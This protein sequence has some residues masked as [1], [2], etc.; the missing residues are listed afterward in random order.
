LSPPSPV[1]VTKRQIYSNSRRR[2]RPDR[3]TVAISCDSSGSGAS[4]VS[5]LSRGS[6]AWRVKIDG[7]PDFSQSDRRQ[8]P[9]DER[10]IWKFLTKTRSPEAAATCSNRHRHRVVL[11]VVVITDGSIGPIR[12]AF[13]LRSRSL[14]ATRVDMNDHRRTIARD[15]QERAAS[16]RSCNAAS[17][18]GEVREILTKNYVKLST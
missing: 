6:R 12:T 14:P 3:S 4:S 8:E 18:S 2:S 16:S 11:R 7:Q 17:R 1:S 15:R 13:P 5:S 9:P 10:A